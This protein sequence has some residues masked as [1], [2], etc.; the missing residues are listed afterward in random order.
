MYSQV[1]SVL[2]NINANQGM[3][4]CKR[5]LVFGGDNFD[6]LI[7]RIKSD[8]SPTWSL[9][10]SGSLVKVLLELLNTSKVLVD[11]LLERAYNT[12]SFSIVL[13]LVENSIILVNSPSLSEP[14]PSFEG[15]KFFQKREWLM[16]P[17]P[18]NLIADWSSICLRTSAEETACAYAFSAAFRPLT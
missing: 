1:V 9:N 11:C 17:P 13:L 10:S 14:P 15:A 8:P 3:V 12:I 4:R 18:L 6:S 7:K 5:I 2:P 16:W